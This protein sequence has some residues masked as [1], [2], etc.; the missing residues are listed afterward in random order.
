MQKYLEAIRSKVCDVCIDGVFDAEGHFVKCGLPS[1]R[2]CPVEFYLPEL[3]DVIE[4]VESPL[5]DDY[6]EVLRERICSHC[7]E[8]EEGICA[9]RIKAEC[10]LDTYFMLVAEAIEEVRGEKSGH[11]STN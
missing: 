9:L 10:P 4:S 7:Q 1:D 3:V 8:N 6:V 2:T 11:V 5:M